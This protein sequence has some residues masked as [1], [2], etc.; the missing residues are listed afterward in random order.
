MKLNKKKI[1]TSILV[2]GLVFG[3]STP[4]LLSADEVEKNEEQMIEEEKET[5]IETV[6]ETTTETSVDV[7]EVQLEKT[8]KIQTK[9]AT[10]VADQTTL[11]DAFP[12]ANFRTYVAESILGLSSGSYSADTK[13]TT[14]N[15]TTISTATSVKV[16]NM[17]ISSLDGIEHFTKLRSLECYNNQLTELNVA[18][19]ID[20]RSLQCQN[21]QISTLDVGALVNL[22]SISCQSNQL[23]ELNVSALVNLGTLNCYANNISVLDVTNLINLTGLQCYNNNISELN[24]TKLTK[25]KTL[26]CANNNISTL[27]VTKL[28]DLTTLGCY[29]NKIEVLNVTDLVS[30]T[31]LGCYGNNIKVLDVSALTELTSL[32][33]AGNPISVLDASNLNKVTTLALA[34]T[35]VSTLNVSAAAKATITTLRYDFTNIDTLDLTGFTALKTLSATKATSGNLS[36]L[37]YT[38][39]SGGRD[40]GSA[41][42]RITGDAGFMTWDAAS[43]YYVIAPGMNVTYATGASYKDADGNSQLAIAE[44]LQLN[45]GALMTSKGDLIIGADASDVDLSTGSVNLPNGVTYITGDITYVFDGNTTITDDTITTDGKVLVEKNTTTTDSDTGKVS[46]NIGGDKSSITTPDGE[47]ASL[48][49]DTGNLNLPDDTI[50]IDNDENKIYVTGETVLDKDGNL[51]SNDSVIKVP[52]DKVTD[53]VENEDGTIT[54]PPGTSIIDKDGNVTSPEGGLIYNPETGEMIIISSDTLEITGVPTG[55]ITVGDSFTLSTNIPMGEWSYDAEYL[56]A[57]T[58]STK[59][60]ARVLLSGDSVTYTAKKSGTT[61]ISYS[62][63]GVTKEYTITIQEKKVDPTDPTEPMEP[64]DPVDPV[65]PTNPEDPSKPILPEVPTNKPSTK[66]TISGGTTVDANVVKTGDETNLTVL[67][68]MLTGSLLG[69]VIMMKKRKEVK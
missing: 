67:Y 68:T 52:S 16:I 65:D 47:E 45:E 9:V 28:V 38:Y 2:G 8:S 21:N 27:D 46:V 53:I 54:M 14:A 39:L 20:L 56:E 41:S 63:N 15:I 1:S 30:L 42:I 29:N 58:I 37:T 35:N 64:V 51:I 3:L 23:T 44:Y 61:T 57:E 50:I 43:N 66:P 48:D 5:V 34:N 17:N 62:I 13:L 19:L 59:S 25:L 36:N 18:S 60:L 69:L 10:L 4:S 49:V 40:Y 11:G 31:N 22:T 55:P 24:V 33:C 32:N 7:P 12:D 6:E 26:N